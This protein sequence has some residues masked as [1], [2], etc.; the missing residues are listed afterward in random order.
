ME[1]GGG[2]P[3]RPYLDLPVI[4][5]LTGQAK[6]IHISSQTIPPGLP[7]MSPLVYFPRSPSTSPAVCGWQKLTSVRFCKKLRFSVRFW[8]YKINCGFG[9]SVW[10]LHCVLFNVYALYWVQCFPVYCFVCLSFTCHC[11]QRSSVVQE[12]VV[13]HQYIKTDARHA[14]IMLQDE[15]W[16]R[17]REKPSPNCRSCFF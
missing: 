7:C 2:R 3:V 15:L 8:F 12:T 5:I 17:Q 16:M 6:T 4:L 9:C 14:P 10:F 11:Q 1:G 13:P